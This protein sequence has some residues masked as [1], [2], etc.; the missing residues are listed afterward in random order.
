MREA[1]I[2]VLLSLYRNR[3]FHSGLS[4]FTERFRKRMVELTRD[5]EVSVAVRAVALV[6]ELAQ[7]DVRVHHFAHTCASRAHTEAFTH[8][9]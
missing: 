6:E 4:M 5:R 8:T 9:Y 2:D 1:A 7:L 3:E